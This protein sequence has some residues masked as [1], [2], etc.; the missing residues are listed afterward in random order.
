MIIEVGKPYLISNQ[1]KKAVV[2]CEFFSGEN[3]RLLEVQ[4]TWRYG[5]YKI[6][7]NN[8]EEVNI[9]REAEENFC[10][11]EFEDW[12]LISTFDGISVDYYFHW[13]IEETEKEKFIE[14]LE[15]DGYWSYLDENGWDAEPMEVWIY[16]G[17]DIKE[18]TAE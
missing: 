9:L 1:V 10:V 16:D 4:T 2:E 6:T 3:N 18:G 12:E 13:N 15:E 7:P 17:I 5:E 11:S 14:N 8:D